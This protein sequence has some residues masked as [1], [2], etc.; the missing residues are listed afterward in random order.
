MRPLA[1]VPVRRSLHGH[2]WTLTPHVLHVLRPEPVPRDEPWHTSVDD[3]A[4]GPVRLTG[5][6][7]DTPH[8][9]TCV[10]LVHGLG[11]SADSR[12]VL[13]AAREARDVGM[14]YLRLHCRGADRSGEDIYHAA[15]SDD[16]RAA[17]AS[18]GLAKFRRI[19]VI[20]FSM[21]GHMALRW[22]HEPDRDPRVAALIAVCAPLDLAYGAN[23]IQRPGGLPYQWHVLRGLK[24]IYRA[25]A[26]RRAMPVPVEHAM[27]LR[28]ILEWDD[29]VVVPRFGWRDRA[30]YYEA[31][32]AGPML[33]G[34]DLPTLFVAAHQD[35]VVTAGGLRP[36]LERASDAV[37][38]AWTEGGH[39]G[40]PDD[41]RL[42]G[43]DRP[44][45]LEPQLFRW[46]AR[47][48][49]PAPR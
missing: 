49:D 43:D 38:V 45:P 42:V 36:W 6:L 34:C 32:S 29:E 10:V 22:A 9:D 26:A 23:A 37:E 46:L 21:G 13:R 16:L 15:L 7:R 35:P 28:T 5:W 39:I 41:L 4:H 3:P 24:E 17:L 1:S 20:G 25:A 27:T 47:A 44:G 31:A 18:P 40:F 19:Y 30:H 2:F 33:E 48:S 12:Y 8:S 11:G 14:S